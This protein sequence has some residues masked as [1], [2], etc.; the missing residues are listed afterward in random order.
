MDKITI[1]ETY[2]DGTPVMEGDIIA[3]GNINDIIWE[4][5][6]IVTRRPLGI[7][8]TKQRKKLSMHNTI[9]DKAEFYNVEEIRVGKAE[10][11][12]EDEEWFNKMIKDVPEEQR[13]QD[14]HLSTWDGGFYGWN[15]IEKIGS[16]YDFDD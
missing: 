5:K 12:N 10:F 3:E 14:L 9:L 13:Y 11:I 16:I 4:G 2:K 7:V 8:V 6:A 15:D 1:P